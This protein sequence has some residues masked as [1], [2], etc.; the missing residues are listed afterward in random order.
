MDLAEGLRNREAGGDWKEFN[1]ALQEIMDDYCGYVRS[2]SL[3]E[4]GLKHLRRI[5]TKAYS[6][7]AAKD[8]WQLT[9]CLETLNLLDLCEITLIAADERK[10]TRC[11][12]FRVDYPFTNA[13]LDKTL[14]SIKRV[15]NRPVTGWKKL[16]D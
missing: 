9:R 14:L 5:K 15:N 11:R 3:L 10:E 4:A 16:R 8:A 1:F 7:M 12:H 13:M 6:S 2:H